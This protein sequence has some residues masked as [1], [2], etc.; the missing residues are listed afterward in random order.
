MKRA[1]R[2]ALALVGA[3]APVVLLPAAALAHPLGNFTVNTSANLVLSPGAIRVEYVLD[4]A[5][6]P[7]VQAMPELDAD[8]D[9]AVSAG[10]AEAW[11]RR[12][13]GQLLDG[14]SL[15]IDGEPVALEVWSSSA[16]L[17]A[18]QGGLDVLR[19]EAVFSGTAAWGAGTLSFRDGN[20]EGRVGW[21]EV[22]AVGADGVSLAA[23]N[24][25]ATSPSDRLRAYPDDLLSS[26][27]DVREASLRYAPGEGTT[28]GV[29]DRSDAAGSRPGV[30]GGAFADLI[31]R[32]GPLM[33]LALLVAFGFGA[34]HAL[35]PGHGKTLM[36]A[37]LVGAGGRIRQAVAVGGAVALMHTA[38]VLAL[39]LVVLSATE[40]FA[41]ERV[42]PWL[43]LASGLIALGLGAGLLV[44]R[45]GS[46][47]GARRRAGAHLDHGHEHH[48]H[49]P[50]GSIGHHPHGSG[51]S[52]EPHHERPGP[53]HGHH[54]P[55]P[56]GPVWSRRGLLA[57]AVA[58]GILPSPTA[59]VV[60]LAAVALRRVA[61]GL[62]LIGTFSL[63][64]AAA[65]VVVGVVAL[66]ARDLVARRMSGR[67]AR[68]LPIASA[69][70]IAAM[71]IALVVNGA[72]QV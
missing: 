10:E 70:A 18:G 51:H 9:G 41:P 6:I 12:R 20:F 14:L 4:L 15:A 21:H 50:G 36:A 48:H 58:G 65:L 37:Y 42:Y 32:T 52:T 34:L 38:S 39:G 49:G 67:V 66:R 57:L 35:G 1:A 29:V 19:L 63:G 2:L 54:H 11:S 7:T 53:D 64:L 22:T 33:L 26:P 60:L 62:A 31:E 24:A 28:V 13:A 59:L 23:S 25:P 69:A 55:T 45:L 47:G 72:A 30:V 40:V 44:V 61:Y 16:A 8:G 5:E 3:V 68:M 27:L 17:S 71:G 46:W 56:E 43:G